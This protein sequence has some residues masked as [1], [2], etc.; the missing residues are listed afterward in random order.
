MTT[1]RLVNR[2]M[3]ATPCTVK[4][5]FTAGKEEF[6]LYV[7]IPEGAFDLCKLVHAVPPN[8]L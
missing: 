4:A 3:A 8:N 5:E 2:I 6:P 1:T 7:N